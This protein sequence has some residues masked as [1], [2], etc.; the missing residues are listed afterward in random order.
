MLPMYPRESRCGN[1]D[2]IENLLCCFGGSEA[3]TPAPSMRFAVLCSQAKMSNF[4]TVLA[5]LLSSFWGC[6]RQCWC[7]AAHPSLR[8]APRPK[9]S[10]AAR[11][12]LLREG[13]ARRVSPLAFAPEAKGDDRTEAMTA[14][15]G[16]RGEVL[17]DR[18]NLLLR[19]GDCFAKE[20]LAMTV[21]RGRH[22]RCFARNDS[23]E[24]VSF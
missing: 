18:G 2:C 11:G 10:P 9:Q 3:E 8:G 4:Y 1:C 13:A 14:E 7:K 6:G 17:R 5:Q 12:G 24:R 20:P 16:R 15:R 23:G 22:G 21:E 19:G